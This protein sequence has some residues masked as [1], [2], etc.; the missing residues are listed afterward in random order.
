MS[1]ASGPGVRHPGLIL[2]VARFYH[3][4]RGSVRGM[5]D[6]H[7]SEPRLLAYAVIAALVLLAGRLVLVGMSA[8]GN[9]LPRILEQVV[10]IVFFLPL[11]YYGLAALGTMFAR[12]AGGE[13]SWQTG[14]A[15]FFWAALCSA[16]FV[17]LSG[18]APVLA[19][20]NPIV[21]NTV[22]MLGPVVL[23]IA[24]AYCFAEAFGFRR[25]WTVA[26]AMVTPVAVLALLAWVLRA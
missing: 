26:A 25:A 4:P 10:S 22:A 21:Q 19:G 18:L 3:D 6:S 16:P 5:L 24:V 11:A 12:M 9:L 23:M 17:A 2:G 14:R 13:G 8:E 7:P 1:A 15:A 20:Q